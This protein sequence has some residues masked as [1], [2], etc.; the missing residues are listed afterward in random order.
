MAIHSVPSL[1]PQ[2]LYVTSHELHSCQKTSRYC[3]LTLSY[4]IIELLT[5]NFR[6]IHLLESG[7]TVAGIN[8]THILRYVLALL[9]VVFLTT[10]QLVHD[11]NHVLSPTAKHFG[12]NGNAMP[13]YDLQ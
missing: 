4:S 6:W 10:P 1:F 2:W 5:P 11:S 9:Y 12:L 7:F 8:R 3:I 13:L